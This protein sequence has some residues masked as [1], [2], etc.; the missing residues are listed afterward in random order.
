MKN[1]GIAVAGNLIVDT[2]YPVMGFAKPGELSNICGELSLATGG[3]VCNN[4]MDLATLDPELPLVALGR[5]GD[6]ENGRYVQEKLSQFP[7]IDRQ[8]L[9]IGGTTAYIQGGVDKVWTFTKLYNDGYV[10]I[11]FGEFIGTNPVEK[12]V[13]SSS[14]SGLTT[15]TP[16]QLAEMTVTS[17]YSISHVRYSVTDKTGSEIHRQIAFPYYGLGCYEM[18]VA[19]W[20]KPEDFLPFSGE[21]L[22]VTCRIST[23]ETVTLFDG[24]IA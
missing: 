22:T 19:T 4:I 23:G 11:T 1:K 15:V 2:L 21:R 20:V 12:S 13:T 9:K 3:A 10:P 7:N 5:I 8:H 24:V 14:L 6:D 16:A 18:D 17:N